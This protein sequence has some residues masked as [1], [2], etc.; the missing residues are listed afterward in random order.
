MAVPD[1]D[2]IAGALLPYEW[3]P[4]VSVT[5]GVVLLLYLRGLRRGP[6]RGVWRNGAF[7]L[8][9]ALTYGVSQTQFDYFAQFVFFL[10]RLQHLILHH[11]GA[12][13]LVLSDPLPA[14]AAGTPQ[15]LRSRFIEPLWRSRPVQTGYRVIQQPVVASLLFVGLIYLWLIPTVHL[16]AML[17]RELYVI[18]N[19][20]MAIDGI[21]F[22]WLALNPTPP[23]ISRTSMAYGKRCLMLAAVAFPQIALGAWI[24]IDGGDIYA[25]YEAC[26]SPWPISATTDRVLGGVLTWIPPAMMSLLGVLIVMGMWHRHER[27]HEP[28]GIETTASKS[29]AGGT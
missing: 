4:L 14:L 22:W 3:Q 17:S 29:V 12:M 13:L 23:G 9:L 25:Y 6:R 5:T 1:I 28:R 24:V 11:V 18:M 19:W 7:F 20:S 21:L 15:R 26:G 2:T 27:R 10:H 8:G 16:D